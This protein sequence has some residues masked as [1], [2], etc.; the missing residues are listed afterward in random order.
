MM[1]SGGKRPSR[2]WLDVTTSQ[3]SGTAYNGTVRVER[4]LI[5]ELPRCLGDRLA[6][7][8]FN[9]SLGRFSAVSA[10]ALPV[11]TAAAP[12]HER[13]NRAVRNVGRLVERRVRFFVRAIIRWSSEMNIIP[14]RSH[15]FEASGGDIILLAG[16]NW[17]RYDFSVLRKLK[18]QRGIRFAVVLQDLA[19]LVCPQFFEQGPFLSRFKDY[20]D[21]LAA[22]ADTV[23]TIS[24]STSADF[25]RATAATVTRSRVARI[26]LGADAISGASH[27]RPAELSDD[28]PFVLSVS[29]IQS[30][31][32]F[33]LLYRLWQRFALDREVDVPRLVIVGRPGFGGADLLHQI[34]NDPLVANRVT[35][36]GHASDSELGW[37]YRNCLFTVYPSWYEGWGL[38]LTE[39]LAYGKTFV[40]SDRS[41]LPEAGQG[42]GIHLD[43]YDLVAWR[44]EVLRLSRNQQARHAL[45]ER[46]RNDRRI[47]TWADSARSVVA[48]LDDLQSARM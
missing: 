3:A 33:D 8:I 10:P 43:P 5:R 40:A 18:Q 9:Q 1:T 45:E 13:S 39:S 12:V 6:F 35:L 24:D 30:R 34:R 4:S 14:E 25:Q 21:F 44:G 32:N 37:L 19:P 7:C 28:R 17:S 31:K 11:M 48:A 2:I 20:I 41:S 23:L 42:L 16:E 26:E 36:I 38:P 46:I 22:D 47:P 27:V 15:S 29:T